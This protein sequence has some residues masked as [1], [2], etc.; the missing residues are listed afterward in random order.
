MVSEK[1]KSG[2]LAENYVANYFEKLGYKIV[3]RNYSV[4]F[5]GEVDIIAKHGQNIYFI[6]VKARSNENIY[7]GM[8][9]SIS[10]NKLAKIKKCASFY[11]Q[12]NDMKDFYCKVL[13]AFVHITP[14]KKYE[15]IKIVDLD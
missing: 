9:G 14:D 4:P 8:E 2:N 5:V 12:N 13:G 6:E 10:Y 11:L 7:G 15:N 3:S 1:R